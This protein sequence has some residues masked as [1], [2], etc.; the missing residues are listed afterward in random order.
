MNST[1]ESARRVHQVGEEH[2]RGA[3]HVLRGGAARARAGR[4]G[5]IIFSFNAGHASDLIMNLISDRQYR[6]ERG[7]GGGRRGSGKGTLGQGKTAPG[8]SAKNEDHSRH[9]AHYC[10]TH[11]HPRRPGLFRIDM[12]T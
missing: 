4:N 5:E 1:A 9:R 10:H 12:I 7:S 8:Q 2:H 6:R 11:R 3:R